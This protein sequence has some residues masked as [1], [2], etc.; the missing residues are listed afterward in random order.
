MSRHG[1]QIPAIEAA[2]LVVRLCGLGLDQVQTSQPLA[3]LKQVGIGT[4]S[5]IS[6]FF[7]VASGC[8]AAGLPGRSKSKV[9]QDPN[10]EATS[11]V[12]YFHL[13]K[14]RVCSIDGMDFVEEYL[15]QR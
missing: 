6:G 14:E 15:R 5:M 13:W 10:W 2:A 11:I 7:G 1:C 12:D 4:S 9:F 3:W 8:H